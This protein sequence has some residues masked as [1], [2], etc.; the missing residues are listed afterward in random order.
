ML[1]KTTRRRQTK[2]KKILLFSTQ[3]GIE[4]LAEL[5]ENNMHSLMQKDSHPKKILVI[6]C[7]GGK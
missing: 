4:E 5:F 1:Y 2:A 3:T 6:R 7:G